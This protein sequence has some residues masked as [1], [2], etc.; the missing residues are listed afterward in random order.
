MSFPSAS[1]KHAFI[2]GPTGQDGSYLADMLLGKEYEVWGCVR[3]RGQG[4]DLSNL[5]PETVDGLHW[6]EADI[7]DSEAL[8][9]VLAQ[10]QPDEVYNLAAM[11]FV[12]ASWPSVLTAMETNAIGAVRVFEACRKAC[13][14][15]RVY[16]ASSSEMFGNTP[17][18]QDEMTPMH[19]VSPY[20]V[21]KLAAHRMAHVYRLSY[22][23]F[24]A[25]GLLFNHESPR[26]GN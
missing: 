17:P 14:E 18:P 2:I 16:Q 12:P 1:A 26:R 6:V 8:T 13:P 21:A 10:C 23:Q 19:P 3:P 9:S 22:G 7:N 24:I 5:L 20:G 4:R 11:S 15:A 25:C